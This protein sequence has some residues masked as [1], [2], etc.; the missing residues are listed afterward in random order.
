MSILRYFEKLRFI[1]SLIRKKATGNQEEFSRKT[2]LSRSAL[3]EYL[4]EMKKL[5]FPICFCRRLNSYYYEE[6][7][8]MVDSLFEN[9]LQKGE[10]REIS[11]G[12]SP[13]WI[14]EFFE[15]TRSIYSFF[16]C[17]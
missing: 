1:D 6:E 12:N 17:G 4:K 16:S 8:S 11:G 7:G 15:D 5:G 14:D 13:I 10:M 9:K 2:G 3:N